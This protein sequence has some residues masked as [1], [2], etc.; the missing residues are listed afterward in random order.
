MTSP[1]L[2]AL[3]RWSCVNNELPGVSCHTLK[4]FYL[5]FADITQDVDEVKHLHVYDFDN[6][7]ESSERTVPVSGSTVR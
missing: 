5:A 4:S 7:R 1:R 2:E 6:T 3:N